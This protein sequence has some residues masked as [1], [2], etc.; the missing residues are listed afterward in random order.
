MRRHLKSQIQS[1]SCRL[2]V[3][4]LFSITNL[5]NGVLNGFVGPL[6]SGFLIFKLNAD[7]TMYGL[8]LSISSSLVTGLV[9]IPG[10]I[11]AD[12]FGRKPL[13][14][15]GFLGAPLVFALAFSRTFLE[16]GLIMSGISAVGNISSPAISVGSWILFHKTGAPALVE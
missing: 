9:Q 13:V 16:F 12:K 7:P 2:D 5:A 15:L 14:L 10:G 6:L 4:L 3:I 11:L 8:I 1:H